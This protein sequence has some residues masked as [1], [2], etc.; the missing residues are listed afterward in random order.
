MMARTNHCHANPFNKPSLPAFH[1][2]RL[3]ESSCHSW[4][5]DYRRAKLLGGRVVEVLVGDK[6]DIGFSG[7]NGR[8]WV[9]FAKKWINQERV[10]D[11]L[12]LKT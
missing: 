1:N 5:N 3:A 2:N 4:R 9:F 10:I 7:V 11:V 12:H 8:V 6:H